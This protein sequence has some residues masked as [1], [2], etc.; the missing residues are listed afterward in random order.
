MSLLKKKEDQV[1][2]LETGTFITTSICVLVDDTNNEEIFL[3]SSSEAH[4]HP[5]EN[6]AMMY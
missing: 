1:N 6:M 3:F 2:V 5:K 4:T